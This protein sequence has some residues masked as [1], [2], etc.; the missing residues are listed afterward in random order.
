M[1]IKTITH[2]NNMLPKINGIVESPSQQINKK[3][4][5]INIQINNVII[6]R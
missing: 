1:Q 2:V 5:K 4:S 3:H 6:R